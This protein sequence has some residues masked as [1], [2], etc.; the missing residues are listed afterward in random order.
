MVKSKK[1]AGELA[2]PFAL[3]QR[4]LFKKEAQLAGG[5][6][7]IDTRTMN[8]MADR[9]MAWAGCGKAGH[10]YCAMIFGVEPLVEFGSEVGN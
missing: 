5:A 10:G 3:N 8:C 9:C 2:C 4:L 6:P 1:E 7:E